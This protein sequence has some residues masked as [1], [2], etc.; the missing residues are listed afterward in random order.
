MALSKGMYPAGRQI[1]AIAP[2]R[3]NGAFR[4]NSSSG[5]V[6]GSQKGHGYTV[7]RTSAGLY[8]I[9]FDEPLKRFM[10]CKAFV[11][12]ADGRRIAVQAGDYNASA[13]TLQLR[14]GRPTG[15]IQLDLSS[16]RIIAAN[17][18][19][20]L[21][22][23]GFADGNT[24][25]SLQRVNGATDK[26]LRIIWAAGDSAELQFAPVMYPPDLD[27]SS[28]VT[29]KLLMAKG[30]NTDTAAV[31]AVA[32]FEG[33]GDTDMG[34]NTAALAVS[35]L[36]SYSRTLAAANIGAYPSFLNLSL[37]PGTHASDAIYLYGAAVEYVKKVEGVDLAADADNEILF[38]VL[39]DESSS[40]VI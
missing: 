33:V 1:G 7:A 38:E 16:A 22:E 18:I 27:D 37:I 2:V 8:T 5:I 11:R 39:S 28:D 6:S 20:D 23:G 19:Q 12:E 21:S 35:T 4:P 30:S 9:T 10:G 25:P 36:A 24:S 40:P 31:V 26:A 13:K 34:G 17:V 15:H 32:A 3:I 29:I 14:V